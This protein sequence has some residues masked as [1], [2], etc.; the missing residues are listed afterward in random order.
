MP[1][2]PETQVLGLEVETVRKEVPTLFD[3]DDT[4]YSTIEKRDVEIVSN[5]SMRIPLELRPGG[6]F[7]HYDPE[8]GSLGRGDGPSFDKA[9][10]DPV[11]LKFGIEWTKK[12]EWATDSSTKAVKNI[13][14]HLTATGMAE[15]RRQVDSLC[16]T[17]GTGVVGNVSTY[18]VGTGT[19]GG[20]RVTLNATGDGWGVRLLRFGQNVNVYATGLGTNRTLGGER[21]INYYDLAGKIVDL[22]PSLATG[23]NTDKIVVSGLTATPPVSL[24]G[25]QYHHSDA[26]TG[27]WLGFTR[28]T[29][30]EIRAN[31]VTATGALALPYARL[32]MNKVRDRAGLNSK[33]KMAAWTHPCQAQAY[34]ELG[35]LVS[36]LNKN[37]KED[38]LN[39]YFDD[40]MQMAGA[41]VMQHESWDKTRIDFIVNDVW[42]RA[43][44][45]PPDFYTVD[46]KRIFEGR[47]AEG[48]VAAYQ[49]FYL[50]ASFN[51]FVS[52]PAKC[53]YI[54]NLTVPSGY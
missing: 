13:F 53:V 9:T 17:D 15:F 45:T 25:V 18:S 14:K 20:D 19:A 36:V 43:E 35:Q 4:F 41:P 10:I 39:L 24:L 47:S 23:A 54:S 26:S 46:G 50:K 3:R 32:A 33:T 49:I 30:P 22:T 31:R 44:F 29:T 16:M 40:N 34:E 37:P 5:R 28:S 21:T 7:G 48:G 12:A 11:H 38:S 1:G 2:T 6:K 51:L 52:N 8:G 42:G 27:T